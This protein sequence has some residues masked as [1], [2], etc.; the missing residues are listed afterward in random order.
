MVQGKIA[1]RYCEVSVTL[2]QPEIQIGS[3][4]QGLHAGSGLL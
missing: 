2:L 4:D 1:V 3:L